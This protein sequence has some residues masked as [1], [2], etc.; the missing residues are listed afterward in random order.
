MDSESLTSRFLNP[1]C[2]PISVTP[3]QRKAFAGTWE[4]RIF[5]KLCFCK[6]VMSKV[7]KGAVD[8]WEARQQKLKMKP[9][10]AEDPCS[11]KGEINIWTP[12]NGRIMFIS[13]FRPQL[14]L[15]LEGTQT[16]QHL[17]DSAS[18]SG[19]SFYQLSHPL[20]QLF[21]KMRNLPK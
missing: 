1:K 12:A 2:D 3:S 5:F 9:E 15:V 17:L 11:S 20:W 7:G 6:N 19:S 14:C 4:Q 13:E 10:K 21:S 18:L 16:Q 8:L